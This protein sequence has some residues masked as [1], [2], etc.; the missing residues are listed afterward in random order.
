MLVDFFSNDNINFNKKLTEVCAKL[1]LIRP[2]S[3]V[4]SWFVFDIGIRVKKNILIVG[5]YA[6]IHH[7]DYTDVK[8]QIDD[9]WIAYN[10][11]VYRL[12]REVGIYEELI[13][14]KLISAVGEL[15]ILGL[16]DFDICRKILNTPCKIPTFRFSLDVI[17]HIGLSSIIVG[18]S[19]MWSID[20]D[21]LNKLLDKIR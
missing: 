12:R 11:V 14:F 7:N 2:K 3:G 16:S 20:D 10:L 4:L 9:F 15:D 21:S 17:S 19:D 5:R 8:L 13:S 6:V 1:C 18:Y